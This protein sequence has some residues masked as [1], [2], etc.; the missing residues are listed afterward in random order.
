MY[1]YGGRIGGLRTTVPALFSI[2][3]IVAGEM[4][5]L[6]VWRAHSVVSH[7]VMPELTHWPHWQ[8]IFKG[9]NSDIQ[10]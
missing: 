8:R 4:T 3:G 6:V 9:I 5:Q 2:N 1:A 10:G 7:V